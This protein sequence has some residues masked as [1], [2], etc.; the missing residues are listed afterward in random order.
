MVKENQK[1]LVIIDNCPCHPDLNL[2]NIKVV[3]LPPSTTSVTQ[4]MDQEVI[5]CFKTN[6]RK[7]VVRR[8]LRELLRE[9]H[10]SLNKLLIDE[11]LEK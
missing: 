3:F 4:P 9:L 10:L 11:E 1:I 2:S 7:R 6:Y 5:K 8:L